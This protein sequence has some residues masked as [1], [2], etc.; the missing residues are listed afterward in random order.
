MTDPAGPGQEPSVTG[1]VAA[2]QVTPTSDFARLFED[3][4]GYVY[5]SLRRLGV[6]EADLEDQVHELFLRVHRQRSQFD[7]ARPVRPWLFAFAAR[8][9][10]EY[11]RLARNR[12]EVPGL[13]EELGDA[14]VGHDTELQRIELRRRVLRALE[15]LD[16]DR[17]TVLVALDIDG[18]S[19]PEMAAAL[20]IPLN[21]VYSRL[22]LARSDFKAAF[23]R[24]G[25]AP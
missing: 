4:F 16:F 10:S 9:A 17:R 13:P 24:L 11:R 7:P 19:A 12:R 6:R 15:A 21:T 14:S 5:H 18:H 22:R 8:V 25:G 2:A 23:R 20:G 1:T 3:E